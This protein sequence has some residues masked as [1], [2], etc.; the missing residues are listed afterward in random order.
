MSRGLDDERVDLT[1][2]TPERSVD[3]RPD[4]H[5][6]D[7]PMDGLDLP[8]GEERERFDFRDREYSLN[9]SE[10]RA[11]ATVGAFRVMS[12][13]DLDD[14]QR[15]TDAWHGDWRHLGE[16]GLLTHETITD[17]DG[18]HHVVA[19]TRDG[20]DLLDAHST[21]RSDGH[22]QEYYA[23]IVKPR[24][25]RHDAQLYRVFKEEAA[26]IERDGGRVTRVVLD[27]ELKRDYQQFLNREDR[28]GDADPMAERL[29]FAQ[30]HDLSVVGGHLELPDLRIEYE[31]EYGRTEHRDVELV[32]EHYSRGQIAGKARAGFV[33]YRAGGTDNRKGGTPFDPRHLER[34]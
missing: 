5:A 31:N 13:E 12:P 21:T 11:L 33:C 16:Q 32:T 8:R 26:L 24:E 4:A 15:G 22:R 25:L 14:G 19:L 10:T 23:D 6:A 7:V 1:D 27:Y 9:G 3:R 18:A 34:L 2:R 17:R 20:K 30:A 29:A 28:D